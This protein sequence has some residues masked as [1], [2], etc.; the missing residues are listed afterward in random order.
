MVI[1]KKF[2]K[3][4]KVLVTGNTGFKG[5]WLCLFLN[6]LGAK[7]YG[8]SLKRD[9]SKSL[10][11]IFKLEKVIKTF[12]VDIN[13]KKIVKLIQKINPEILIHFAAQSLVIKGYQSPFLTYN[14]NI[15][16]TLNVLRGASISNKLRCILI[17]TTDKVYSNANIRKNKSHTETDRLGGNDPYSG[18]KAASEILI[19]SYYKS[20]LMKK[21]NLL[22]V[23]AGNVIGGGDFSKNRLI[24]DFFKSLKKKKY[25]TLR[26]PNSTR[27]WQYVI[28]CI[29][30]YLLMIQKTYVLKYCYDHFNIG[31]KYKKD[32][33]TLQLVKL[34]NKDLNLKIKA[35]VSKKKSYKES[36][37]LKLNTTKFSNF[38]KTTALTNIHN[39][40][41]ETKE[42]YICFLY[43]KKNITK[44]SKKIIKKYI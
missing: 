9:F 13:D 12:F 25:F 19:D 21:K 23:R 44:F 35:Q 2:W 27:P 30:I 38:I 33:T 26:N 11:K 5:A 24:P 42:W 34:F 18:S 37:Y 14:T 36:K 3:N 29:Y 17:S 22:V 39:M 6:L 41:L 15:I 28:D 40:I 7:V 16:G 20:F 1:K 10:F 32:I 43:N 31:P 4:K 8:I